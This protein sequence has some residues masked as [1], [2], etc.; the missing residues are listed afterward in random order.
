[1][2]LDDYVKGWIIGDFLPNIINSKDIEVGVKYYKSGDKECRH[3]HNF[4]DEYT[5]VLT[6]CVKMNNMI[7]RNKEIIF[8]PK[9][10]STDFECLEDSVNL[11]LKTPSIPSDK[12]IINP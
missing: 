7:Y 9:G 3:V 2:N 1:M 8:T 10:I 12:T 5:I 11:V 4:V 6:G